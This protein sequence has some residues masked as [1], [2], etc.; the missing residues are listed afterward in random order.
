VQFKCPFSCFLLIELSSF[1][2]CA[3]C[4]QHLN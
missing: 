2:F 3:T 4:V 1:S